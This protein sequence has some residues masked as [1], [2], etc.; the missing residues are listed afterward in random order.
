LLVTSPKKLTERVPSPKKTNERIPTSPKKIIE[1]IGR[2]QS[3]GKKKK[4]IIV[5]ETPETD[6]AVQHPPPPALLSP[7]KRCSFES[8]KNRI[9]TSD[10]LLEFRR[11]LKRVSLDENAVQ[12]TKSCILG[13]YD[14][15]SER[16][17][18]I[19]TRA[20]RASAKF[21]DLMET[22]KNLKEST[23]KQRWRLTQEKLAS[24]RQSMPSGTIL[25]RRRLSTIEL[26][27]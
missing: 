3:P 12:N 14:K 24:R 4:N 5:D 13:S 17:N 16:T 27:S 19:L 25:S 21:Q 6:T 8:P 1:A 15:I 10:G 7:S 2:L 18:D 9:K 22:Q 26:D 23:A 20:K 11:K